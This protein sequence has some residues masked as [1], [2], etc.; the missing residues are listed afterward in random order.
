MTIRAQ[1]L[2]LRRKLARAENVAV[3]YAGQVVEVA[4]TDDRFAAPQHSYT[5]GLIGVR[6]SSGDGRARR[7][8]K[9]L[10]GRARRRTETLSPPTWRRVIRTARTTTTQLKELP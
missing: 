1:S 2:E 3:M 10:S 6:G 8:I 5:A 7:A 9:G 4:S